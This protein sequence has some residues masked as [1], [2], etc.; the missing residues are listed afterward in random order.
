V[1]TPTHRIALIAGIALVSAALNL[2]GAATSSFSAAHAAHA[3]HATL[4]AHTA[5]AGSS[6]GWQAP[7]GLPLRTVHPWKPPPTKYS[8][9]HRG[10]DL[11]LCTAVHAPEAG[12]VTFVGTVVDREVITV[13]TD[14]RTKYSFEPLTSKLRKGDRVERGQVLG[15]VSGG[16]HCAN[17]CLHFGVRVDGEYVNPLR[18]LLGRPVLLPW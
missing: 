1:L 4:A 9:G 17:T 16:G 18:F 3:A 12:E 10:I 8:A 13:S 7:C 15:T 6:S 2:A 14:T 5:H 11:N